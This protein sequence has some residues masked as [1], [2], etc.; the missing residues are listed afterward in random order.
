MKQT[1][2]YSKH[3][4]KCFC[5]EIGNPF[6]KFKL[7]EIIN[8]NGKLVIE[9]TEN[10]NSQKKSYSKNIKYDSFFDN[11]VDLDIENWKNDYSN[12]IY[13]GH[14]WNL[15]LN[16]RPSKIIEKHGSNN[17][18]DN[19]IEVINFIQKYYPEFNVD[20]KIRNT[21]NEDDLL[22]LYCSEFSGTSFPEVSIGDKDIFGKNSTDRRLDIVK[23]E[24][25]IYK[26]FRSYNDNKD[27]FLQLLETNRNIEIIEIKTKLNRT[28]IGQI[29]VGEFMFK[30]KYN[31]EKVKKQSYIILVM[32]LWN[33]FVM[34]T[35]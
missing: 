27:Y 14:E 24:N 16:F 13:S 25:D 31:V 20:L 34:K 22:K 15:K 5:L 30:K 12:N 26:W 28:V 17:F 23:I 9:Y 3:Y 6:D 7:F 4:F 8:K 29:I 21:L 32:V 33:Y 11:L 10:E 19:F 2:M 35:I 18:S 1:E